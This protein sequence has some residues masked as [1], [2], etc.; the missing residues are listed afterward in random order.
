M[1]KIKNL[2]EEVKELESFSKI[3]KGGKRDIE[4]LEDEITELKG[5]R[6]TINV[7]S[8]DEEIT[9]YENMLAEIVKEIE[10]MSIMKNTCVSISELEKALSLIESGEKC[11]EK[12]IGFMNS[13]I[14]VF[15]LTSESL[16][17]IF[18]IDREEDNLIIMKINREIEKLLFLTKER[19]FFDDLK[20]ELKHILSITIDG[21]V[22]YE[23]DLFLSDDSLYLIFPSNEP[24][25]DEYLKIDSPK[26]VTFNVIFNELPILTESILL[27]LKSN[28]TKSLFRDE[29]SSTDLIENNEKMKN[30]SFYIEDVNEWALDMAIKE[31][32][33]I[34]K[35]E[36]PAKDLCLIE[37]GVS[38]KYISSDYLRLFKIRKFIKKSTSPRKSKAIDFYDRAIQK[39]FTLDRCN[40]ATDYF[41][42]YSDITHYIK[43]AD[44]S[45]FLDEMNKVREEIF[46]KIMKT[47][48]SVDIDLN[49]PLLRLKAGI[50]QRQFDF[51]ENVDNFISPQ[52]HKF[53]KIQFFE[54]IYSNF[55]GFILRPRKYSTKEKLSLKELAQYFMDISFELDPESISNY[56]KINS[57]CRILGSSLEEIIEMYEHGEINLDKNE[58]R[59][60]VRFGFEDSDVREGFINMLM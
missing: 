27:M 21:C 38:G 59:S 56:D 7:R 44:S 37:N 34:C 2:F 26:R 60:I 47:S 42:M 55:I 22:P 23:V 15:T 17:N 19:D 40:L 52:T 31:T 20:H 8:L 33:S 48:T 45:K 9:N 14:A 24:S 29:Y 41:T 12:C 3:Y 50:K 32:N 13:L 16:K 54:K 36:D 1:E 30:T 58:L 53:F 43:K 18:D 49:E 25:T 28:L 46:Y 10:C 57:F 4:Q 6:N 35:S 51:D 11:L 39:F 5:L